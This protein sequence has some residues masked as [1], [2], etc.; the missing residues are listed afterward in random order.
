VG[1]GGDI[2]LLEK[3]EK[4]NFRDPRESTVA[5]NLRLVYNITLPANPA[6]F[7]GLDSW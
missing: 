2:N 4:I 1:Q 6:W 7:H 3:L 5:H